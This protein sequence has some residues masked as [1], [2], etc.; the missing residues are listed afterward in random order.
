[1]NNITVIIISK[2]DDDVI[3]EAI[4]SAKKLTENIIVVDSNTDNNTYDI[5]RKL[6]AKVIKHPFK[7]FSD[8]RNFGIS[9]ATTDWVY[10]LDSD[11]RITEDFIRELSFVIKGKDAKDGFVGYSI[12]RKTYFFGQDWHFKDKVERVFLR[13]KFVNW[14]GVVHES[15]KADGRIG[16]INSPIVHLTHRNLS[17]MVRKTNEWSNYEAKLRYQNNHPPLAPWRFIRVMATEFFNSYV[18]NKGYKNGTYGMIE[19]IYQSF[20]IFISY[21]KLWELQSADKI[22]S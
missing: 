7:N 13:K 10:Y 5:C 20:S 12:F 17:Q 19:A 22:N 1:M 6:G 11:E 2:E 4:K 21:A 15:P 9:H 8:Q 18:K 3:A 16:Q 14:E